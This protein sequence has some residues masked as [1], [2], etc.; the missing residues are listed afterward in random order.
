MT[1][2]ARERGKNARPL[3]RTGPMPANSIPTGYCRT[4][5][6]PTPQG[7]FRPLSVQEDLVDAVADVDV[8]DAETARNLAI[9]VLPSTTPFLLVQYR[10]PIGSY[11]EFDGAYHNHGQYGHVATNVRSGVVTVRPFGPMGVVVVRLRPEAAPRFL[12]SGMGAF[13]NAKVGLDDM[14]QRGAVSVLEEKVAGARTSV[15]RIA[16]VTDFLRANVRERDPDPLVSCAAKRLRHSPVLRVRLLAADLGV[17]ER[18]LSR[19][20]HAIFGISP[21]EFARLAR[22]EKVLAARTAGLAWANLSYA[23][24]FADQA[25]MIND[26]HAILGASPERVLAPPV[27]DQRNDLGASDRTSLFM[28]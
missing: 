6:A 3:R 11:G 25:H 16:L 7:G 9:K 26:T 21:K 13:A 12:G 15:E 22:L 10:V 20:F 23:C 24:G 4:L 5:Q 8:P 17:S 28:W 1:T 19:R 2:D 18:H 27:P 14:L